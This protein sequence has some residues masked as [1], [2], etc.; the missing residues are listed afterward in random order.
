VIL[1]LIKAASI[2]AQQSDK[3][4]RQYYV[5]SQQKIDS[6]KNIPIRLVAPNY[7]AQNLAFFCK[8]EI[9]MEK[10]TKIPFRFRLGSIEDVDRLEGKHATPISP[11]PY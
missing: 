6:L 4:T 3:L 10:I 11:K 7:Y 9:Q 2:H 5:M 8:K 1:F